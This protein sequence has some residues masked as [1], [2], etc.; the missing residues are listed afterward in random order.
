MCKN[1][2]LPGDLII[3]CNDGKGKWVDYERTPK[4]R[5]L[6]ALHAIKEAQERVTT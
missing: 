2:V 6:K 1:K 5:I 4:R 3:W